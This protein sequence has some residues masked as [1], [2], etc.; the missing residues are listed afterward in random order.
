MK[1]QIEENKVE[2]K[3]QHNHEEDKRSDDADQD[4]INS[5]SDYGD[6]YD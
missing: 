5:S 3:K 2:V 4:F 6:E 1:Q